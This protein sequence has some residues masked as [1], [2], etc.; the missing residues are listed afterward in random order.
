MYKTRRQKVVI[1]WKRKNMITRRKM[2]HISKKDDYS[3]QSYI[4]VG[5]TPSY[6]QDAEWNTY[7]FINM[8]KVSTLWCHMRKVNAFC[9]PWECINVVGW[10][11][12]L[13]LLIFMVLAPL[14]TSD[15]PYSEIG[16]HVWRS[17]PWYRCWNTGNL[18]TLSYSMES[19]S[20]RWGPF[21]AAF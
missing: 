5:S 14:R 12:N 18:L 21:R 15:T 1:L 4:G 17:R 7:I 6:P 16:L 8:Y 9:L 20:F 3:L 2:S 11:G 10:F 13:L 19:T